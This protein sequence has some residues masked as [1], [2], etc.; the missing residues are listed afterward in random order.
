[1]PQ[2][3]EVEDE[4]P[5]GFGPVPKPL[6]LQRLSL[7]GLNRCRMGTQTREILDAAIHFYDSEQIPKVPMALD[8][9]AV[10]RGSCTRRGR[11]RPRGEAV[12]SVRQG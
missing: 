9:S 6:R 2:P 3:M 7:L 8:L 12:R 1:M 10:F 11:R 4:L 5:H